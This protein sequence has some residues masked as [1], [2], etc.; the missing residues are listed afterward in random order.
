[1]I[2]KSFESARLDKWGPTRFPRQASTLQH[3]D[4]GAFSV[5]YFP[6]LSIFYL[7][8]TIKK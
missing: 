1:M 7:S 6:R 3:D 4:T 5:N 8:F 2:K